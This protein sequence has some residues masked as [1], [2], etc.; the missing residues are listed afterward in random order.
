VPLN[1][2]CYEK[3][4]DQLNWSANWRTAGRGGLNRESTGEPEM[5][6]RNPIDR[7][8]LAKYTLNNRALEEE[9]LALFV[10]QLPQSLEQL[11]SSVNEKEWRIAAHTIKGSARAVGAKAL[12]DAAAEAEAV[13]G[14]LEEQARLVAEI[15]RQVAIA[16][17]YVRQLN[18]SAG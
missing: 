16:T 2:F 5:D 12:A 15:D 4:T 14:N 9:I 10:D 6:D 18:A 1:G 7:K 17:R 3:L 11:R 8:H 13:T